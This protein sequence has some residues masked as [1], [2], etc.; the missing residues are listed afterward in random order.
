M[1]YLNSFI[2]KNVLPYMA[3]SI[4]SMITKSMKIKYINKE[5]VDEFLNKKQKIA[6]VFWHGR[7]FLL[8]WTHRMI[9]MVLMTSLSKDGE[10][11]TQ[12]MEKFGYK[13]VRGSSSKGGVSALKGIVREMNQNNYNTAIAVDG[14]RGPLYEVKD[15]IL[16]IA[17]FTSS[18]IIPVSSS[19]YPRKIFEKAWDKYLLPF[20]FSKGIIVYGNPIYVGKN[21]DFGIKKIEIKKELNRITEIAD[22]M[23]L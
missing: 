6:F 11:Q 18:V 2:K 21:D 15:G 5:I 12:I 10:I 13:C 4:I 9:K 20:P 7:Q 17:R 8:V 16:F 19:A 3:Y 14:P 22:K 23:M 1:N